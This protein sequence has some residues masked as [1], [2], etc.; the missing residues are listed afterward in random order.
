MPETHH[1]RLGFVRTPPSLPPPIIKRRTKGVYNES[2]NYYYHSNS[3][4][5]WWYLPGSRACECYPK[6]GIA[7]TF[8]T[9]RISYKIND[10]LCGSNSDGRDLPPRRVV[11]G[12]IPVSRS[13]YDPVVQIGKGYGAFNATTRVQVPSGSPKERR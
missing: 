7:S 11:A 6:G 3:I 5:N 10:L 1:N 9:K 4:V 13:N 2:K 12:S 8:T